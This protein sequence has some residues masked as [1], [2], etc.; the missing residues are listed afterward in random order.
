MFEGLSV[1]LVTPFK[2]GALDEAATERLVDFVVKG[3]T[4][5]LVVAG[6]TGEAANLSREERRRLYDAV[7]RANGGRAQLIA[8][9]GTNSTKDSIEL[10]EE[11]RAQGFDGA[12]IVV[13]YY[14]KP[15]PPGQIAHFNAIARAV[16]IPLLVYNVPS[17]TGTN[18]LPE[19]VAR[20]A[21]TPNIVAL[22]EASGSLDQVSAIRARCDLTI[23]SG[24]DSLTLP[25]LAVGARGVVSVLG[26]VAPRPLKDL[27]SAFDE[28][29]LLD[30][31]RL[32]VKLLPLMRALFLESN[33]GPV[34]SLLADMG[35]A[36]NELRLPLVPVEPGTAQAVR[37]AARA[38][39]VRLAQTAEAG[40]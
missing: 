19:T 1:A 38:A 31:Q 9:T 40:A 28:G 36:A 29:R 18:L 12:M 24:D 21:E 39:G 16:D 33:P 17:R 34:K 27:L 23:L 10:T 3:G 5:V 32:H 14:N 11:A 30:A 13:P 4:D 2:D 26:N 35:I 8:G 6:S 20:L 15:T 37:E 25:M 22:K 7:K